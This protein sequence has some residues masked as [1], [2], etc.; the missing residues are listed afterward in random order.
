MQAAGTPGGVEARLCVCMYVYIYIYVYIHVCVYVC[1]YIY[2]C[3]HV[4]IYIYIY[5]YVCMYACMHVCTHVC[6]RMIIKFCSII[7][8]TCACIRRR[9]YVRARACV[10]ACVSRCLYP[11]P[12]PR[13][14]T[15]ND[16]GCWAVRSA[17]SVCVRAGVCA[18]G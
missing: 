7:V 11:S 4:Y 5:I 15:T 10:C 12:I 2:I 6:I 14:Q 1:I 13:T 18:R 9:V 17:I 3:I 16:S 8:Q